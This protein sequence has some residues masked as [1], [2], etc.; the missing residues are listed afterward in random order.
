MTSRRRVTVGTFNTLIRNDE[1]CVRAG[2]TLPRSLKAN[3]MFQN[4]AIKRLDEITVE[5]LRTSELRNSRK[6]LAFALRVL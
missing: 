6:Q 3:R 5:S 1:C 4:T 2:V